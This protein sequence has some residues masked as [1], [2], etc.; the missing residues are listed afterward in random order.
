[1]L[2]TNGGTG[3]PH[4]KGNGQLRQMLYVL[5]SYVDYRYKYAFM[6]LFVCV[7]MWGHESENGIMKGKYL[8]KAR[9]RESNGYIYMISGGRTLL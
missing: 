5:F 1:M 9:K 8:K 6:Y 7:Y 4:V 2:A 3:G